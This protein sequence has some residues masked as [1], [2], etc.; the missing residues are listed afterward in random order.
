MQAYLVHVIIPTLVAVRKGCDL[1]AFLDGGI[2]VLVAIAGIGVETT[3]RVVGTS[4]VAPDIAVSIR[5]WWITLLSPTGIND[6]VSTYRSL[7]YSPYADSV[8]SV[9]ARSSI[10]RLF[11]ISTQPTVQCLDTGFLSVTDIL[12]S[13]VSIIMA[14][15][16][17]GV[18]FAAIA[19]HAIAVITLLTCLDNTVTTLGR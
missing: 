15:K 17:A 9:L 19:I 4:E 14:R 5:I 11:T 2:T 8:G 1:Q 3:V 18:R 16:P 12:I 6:T 10:G 7:A 13:T